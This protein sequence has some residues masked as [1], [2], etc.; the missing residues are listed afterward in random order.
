M[1]QGLR[2]LAALAE[3]PGWVPSTDMAAHNSLSRGPKV[4][5][6]MGSAYLWY[7]DIYAGK[8]T[9]ICK[10][11]INTSEKQSSHLKHIQTLEYMTRIRC[12]AQW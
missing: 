10:I 11:K 7:P 2:L 4:L 8:K 5:T 3:E 12:V 6:S 1:A 9:L